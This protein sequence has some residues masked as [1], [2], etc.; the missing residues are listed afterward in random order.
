MPTNEL[1]AAAAAFAGYL[2]IECGLSPNTV[3]G[4]QRDLRDLIA[5]L[6]DKGIAAPAA[7]TPQVL[8]RHAAELRSIRRLSP[9]SVA[10]HLAAI[11]MFFRWLVANGKVEADPTELLERP[12]QWSRLPGVVSARNITAIIEAAA[13]DDHADPRSLP[14]W[15]RDRALLEL[16]YASGLRA[17]EATHL[18]VRHVSLDL[19][20]V[21]V[22]GKGNKERIVPFGKPAGAAVR[23]YLDD[24][25]PRLARP[26]G[27]DHGRLLLSR[28]GRPLTR[29]SV[30]DIVAARARQAGL[31]D[32]HP[33]LLRHSFA[34]HVLSGGADLRVV[35]EL[36]GHSNIATTQIYTHVDQPRLK[37]VHQT[38]HP[39][40]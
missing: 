4:Y 22:V 3:L 1:G 18:E 7:V 5:D 33:H 13:P 14:L 37:K 36:L 34:T 38:Y 26:D 32:I 29:A 8:I 35:Q 21:R 40:A 12:S 24:C 10:R 31:K 17:S 27:R 20:V 23:A 30:W 16:L 11:R 39:R 9:A 28:T 19:S 2:K 15:Q 25:R 6:D